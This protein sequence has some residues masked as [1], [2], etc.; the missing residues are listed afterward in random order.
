MKIY[1]FVREY[2]RPL[3]GSKK[4]SQILNKNTSPYFHSVLPILWP[5]TMLQRG[6]LASYPSLGLVLLLLEYIILKEF[7]LILGEKV[8]TFL[9][10]LQKMSS[11][12]SRGYSTYQFSPFDS[13]GIF[14]Y[15]ECEYSK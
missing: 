15:F 8:R 2:L 14:L 9:I 5:L 12:L 13:H 4:Y 3:P 7:Q 10:S 6:I 1:E 11:L